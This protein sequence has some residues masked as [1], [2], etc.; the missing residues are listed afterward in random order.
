VTVHLLVVSSFNPP[1]AFVLLDHLILFLE[2]QPETFLSLLPQE[3][4]GHQVQ[5]ST[6]SF[7]VLALALTLALCVAGNPDERTD[8]RPEK[9]EDSISS[10][11]RAYLSSGLELL[12]SF[13]LQVLSMSLIGGAYLADMLSTILRTA[14]NGLVRFFGFGNSWQ[15]GSSSHGQDSLPLM[16]SVNPWGERCHESKE[17]R[18]DDESKKSRKAPSEYE[19]PAA[20]SSFRDPSELRELREPGELLHP[21]AKSQIRLAC[22]SSSAMPCEEGI[23]EYPADS[24]APLMR[25]EDTHG[26]KSKTAGGTDEPSSSSSLPSPH[27]GSEESYACAADGKEP[28]QDQNVELKPRDQAPFA[29]S[30]HHPESFSPP[31]S[32]DLKSAKPDAVESWHRAHDKSD[33]YEEHRGDSLQ[34]LDGV[35][36]LGKDE[37]NEIL[38]KLDNDIAFRT[39]CILVNFLAAYSLYEL[40]KIIR[41]WWDSGAKDEFTVIQETLRRYYKSRV[42]REY[43]VLFLS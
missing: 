34:W 22:K 28:R 27:T 6:T 37:D 36:V 25:N 2:P 20:F 14:C 21:Q 12:N 29:D 7:V 31:G 4:M 24:M 39:F 41:E 26:S 35:Y 8:Q 13:S 42:S 16:Q 1:T 11:L 15:F 33:S 19:I 32:S 17:N 43:T 10:I 9:K 40:C 18:K 23:R 3:D 38:Q 30:D 5:C